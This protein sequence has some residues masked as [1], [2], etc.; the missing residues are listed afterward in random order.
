MKQKRIRSNGASNFEKTFY[1][2][3][4]VYIE[5]LPE[6]EQYFMYLCY[7]QCMSLEE[8]ANAFSITHKEAGEREMEIYEKLRKLMWGR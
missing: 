3:L 6:E 4:G 5:T 2:V 1:F 7:Q 8:V